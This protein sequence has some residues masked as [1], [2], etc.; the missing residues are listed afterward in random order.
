VRPKR[1]DSDWQALRGT[2]FFSE[3]VFG[4][5]PEQDGFGWMVFAAILGGAM[6]AVCRYG[7]E[8]GPYVQAV[9]LVAPTYI[10]WCVW[11]RSVRTVWSALALTGPAIFLIMCCAF[12][13]LIARGLWWLLRA[14]YDQIAG[15][16]GAS[17]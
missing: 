12:M 1:N 7:I 2:S 14:A 11:S 4:G 3:L 17:E 9:A 6:F 8:L 13:S 15:P 16:G 5:E 10:I